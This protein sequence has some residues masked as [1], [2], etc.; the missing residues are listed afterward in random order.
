MDKKLLV[1]TLKEKDI[2]I[3]PQRLA[4]FEQLRSRK[5]HPSAEM[6]FNELKYDFPSLT[7][8]T[9]YNTLQKLELSGLCMKVNP[10]H[11]S[12]RY[13]G[14]VV[15]HHHAICINCQKVVDVFDASVS[16]ELP[17]WIAEEFEVMNQS[18]SF[19]GLC[20]RCKESIDD[21]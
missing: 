17:E 11:S 2:Q 14:N 1:H 20:K 12:A 8:V 4:I 6:V 13:D 9:V 21:N 18:V 5:D 16:I 15:T 3:T 7:L 19:Y 10:M